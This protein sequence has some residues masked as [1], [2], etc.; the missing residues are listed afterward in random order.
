VRQRCLE[1]LMQMLTTVLTCES[2][3]IKHER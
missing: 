3:R 2:E 1:L